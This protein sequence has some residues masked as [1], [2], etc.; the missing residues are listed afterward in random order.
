M[1]VKRFLKW[2]PHSALFALRIVAVGREG[3]GSANGGPSS[4]AV[5]QGGGKKRV[6]NKP[7][8]AGG[9]GPTISVGPAQLFSD[10]I[11]GGALTEFKLDSKNTQNRGS[12]FPFRLN[13]N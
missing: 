7:R 2:D 12:T 5:I 3:W 6:H 1:V 10:A 11:G 8:R 9:G 13:E 4:G